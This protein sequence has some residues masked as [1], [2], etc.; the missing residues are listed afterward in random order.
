MSDDVSTILLNLC[1]GSGSPSMMLWEGVLLC[2][3][4][5]VMKSSL[6]GAYKRV[7]AINFAASSTAESVAA[8]RRRRCGSALLH[9]HASECFA[10]KPQATTRGQGSG[11][12]VGASRPHLCC[13]L[14]LCRLACRGDI[15]HKVPQPLE[16]ANLG[17][18]CLITWTAARETSI[19]TARLPSAILQWQQHA[20]MPWA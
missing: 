5:L 12:V 20:L 7:G 4:S 15:A 10:R 3:V 14:C 18:L 13:I 11:T 6:P 1:F 9:M 2:P 19:V 8:C 16:G 17:A